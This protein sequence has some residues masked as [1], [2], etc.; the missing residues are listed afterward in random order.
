MTELNDN[1]DT[2]SVQPDAR[3]RALDLA[4]HIDRLKSKYNGRESM[5]GTLWWC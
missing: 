5:R 3:S 2:G 4:E 1:S